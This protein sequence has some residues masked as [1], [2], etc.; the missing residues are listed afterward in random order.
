MH[1]GKTVA[2]NEKSLP[3]LNAEHFFA[4]QVH[5]SPFTAKYGYE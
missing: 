2:V 5:I 1:R 4:S 3:I